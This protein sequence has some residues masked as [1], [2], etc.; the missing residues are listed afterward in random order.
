M[1]VTGLEPA[2]PGQTI[3]SLIVSVYQFRHTRKRFGGPDTFRAFV[4][5]ASDSDFTSLHTNKKGR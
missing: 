4:C 3:R 1:R 2:R 5:G